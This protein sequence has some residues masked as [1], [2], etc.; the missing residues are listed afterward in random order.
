MK[1][2]A[3]PGDLSS[4]D[5][6]FTWLSEPSNFYN[7]YR[8]IVT[9]MRDVASAS[10]FRYAAQDSSAFGTSERTL[11]TFQLTSSELQSYTDSPVT[12]STVDLETAK[13]KM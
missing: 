7:E 1:L 8:D 12:F 4:S 9:Q 13:R 11:A 2:S 3:A 6:V 10:F 5:K